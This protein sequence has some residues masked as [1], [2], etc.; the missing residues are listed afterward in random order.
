MEEE[1]KMILEEYQP[2]HLDSLNV[3]MEYFEDGE[4]KLIDLVS[5]PK[6]ERQELEEGF[7]PWTDHEYVN[8]TTNGGYTG[9][10]FA[11]SVYIPITSSLYIHFEYWM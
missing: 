6:G 9:D 10:T 8:Q 2:K 3:M 7:F 11:G 4:Y 5:R 1:L